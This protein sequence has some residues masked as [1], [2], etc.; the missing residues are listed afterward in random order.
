MN[1]PNA[2]TGPL[3]ELREMALRRSGIP[4]DATLS[5]ND[6]DAFEAVHPGL[7]DR[8]AICIC[9]GVP[10]DPLDRWDEIREDPLN[11]FSF[12]ADCADRGSTAEPCPKCGPKP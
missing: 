9:C 6:L 7:F 10:H 5:I 11:R 4:A 3:D 8:T 2:M 1:D 12:C